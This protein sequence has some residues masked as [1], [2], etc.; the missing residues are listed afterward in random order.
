M[1]DV[2][3]DPAYLNELANLQRNAAGK[4]RDATGLTEGVSRSLW[5][6]HGPGVF[7]GNIAFGE[8]AEARRDAGVAMERLADSLAERLSAAATTYTRVDQQQSRDIDAQI[9]D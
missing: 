9:Q 5:V 7:L 3:V 4:A 1:D 2:T 8:A 6:S